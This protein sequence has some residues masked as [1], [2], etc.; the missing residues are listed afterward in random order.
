MV[1]ETLNELSQL[2][3]CGF[4]Q[5]QPRHGLNL[6]YWF[7][8]ECIEFSNNDIL[9]KI[10]PQ[11]EDFGFHRFHNRIEEDDLNHL[12][13]LQSLPYYEVGNL[14]AR[15]ADKLP[16]YVRANED[17]D[18]ERN[19]DRII[20]RID[21]ADIERVFITEHSDQKRFDNNKTFRVSKGLL[22]IIKNMTREQYLNSVTNQIYYQYTNQSRVESLS[23]VEPPP[24]QNDSW[25]TIL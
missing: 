21:D 17:R 23:R 1:K 25:C 19:K 11:R 9:C 3:N 12:V 6:L 4:G 10:S 5:P 18:A 16:L 15:G 2:K 13:P 8:H 7:A 24:P 22:Q 20:V 14:N